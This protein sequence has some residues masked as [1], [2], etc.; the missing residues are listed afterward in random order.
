MVTSPLGISPMSRKCCRRAPSPPTDLIVAVL[1]IG[2]SLNDVIAASSL[3]FVYS[4]TDPVKVLRIC[5]LT[6]NCECAEQ[7]LI[8]FIISIH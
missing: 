4:F 3:S 8:L 5:I 6:Y 1:P 7:L 2:S